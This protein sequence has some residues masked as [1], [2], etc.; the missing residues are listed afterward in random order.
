LQAKKRWTAPIVGEQ[1]GN[2]FYVKPG[3]G[4]KVQAKRVEER[5]WEEKETVTYVL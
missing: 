4:R 1:E 3:E 2:P 5:D